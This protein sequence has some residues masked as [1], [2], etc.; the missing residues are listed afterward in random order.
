MSDILCEV[1]VWERVYLWSVS[2]L[3]I[4]FLLIKSG[5]NSHTSHRN[6]NMLAHERNLIGWILLCY[7]L[8]ILYVVIL[9]SSTYKYYV[10]LEHVWQCGSGCF[11]NNFLCRN[12]CQWFFLFL[13]NYFWHQYIKTIQNIQA[14]LNF[15]KKKF[16]IFWEPV[17]TAFPNGFLD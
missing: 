14:I 8:S 2:S 16:W 10:Y 11:S 6:P 15:S 7:V 3:L 5:F 13:K 17:C 1:F 12:A 9:T 4:V